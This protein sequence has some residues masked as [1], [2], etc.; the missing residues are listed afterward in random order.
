MWESLIGMIA[1]NLVWVPNLVVSWFEAELL[2]VKWLSWVDAF[3][4][5]FSWFGLLMALS[6]VFLPLI[7]N[8]AVSFKFESIRHAEL[9]NGD[10]LCVESSL[11]QWGVCLLEVLHLNHTCFVQNHV[12]LSHQEVRSNALCLF[13]MCRQLVRIVPLLRY[14][15]SWSV[16]RLAA[17][18]EILFIRKGTL[19]NL[20]HAAMDLVPVGC[21]PA[22]IQTTAKAGGLVDFKKSWM[23]KRT[24]MISRTRGINRQAKVTFWKS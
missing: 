7:N 19:H 4:K 2:I 18:G 14:F 23:R 22:V 16:L 24:I 10:L 5:T 6:C 17:V 11:Q 21:G 20:V 9:L 8:Y 1:L 12:L 13:L 15:F 3:G